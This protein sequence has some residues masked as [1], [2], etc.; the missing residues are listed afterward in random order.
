MTHD[1]IDDYYA[2]CKPSDYSA[3]ELADILAN[4]GPVDDQVSA[5]ETVSHQPFKRGN[6]A[7]WPTSAN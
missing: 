4:C 2:T 5:I 7:M 6:L 3:S 1:R